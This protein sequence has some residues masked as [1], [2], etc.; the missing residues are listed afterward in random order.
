VDCFLRAAVEWTA[1][2]NAIRVAYP[3]AVGSFHTTVTGLYREAAWCHLL[4]RAGRE[5]AAVAHLQA[6]CGR[7]FGDRL[8]QRDGT[9]A[10][11]VATEF[12]HRFGSAAGAR[13]PAAFKAPPPRLRA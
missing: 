2:A 7:M 11:E 1:I 9:G 5:S 6:I 13:Y 8:A 12:F 3:T 10:V 4:V